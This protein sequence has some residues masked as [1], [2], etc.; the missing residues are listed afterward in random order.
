MLAVLQVI[1]Q[2]LVVGLLCVLLRR[3]ALKPEQQEGLVDV[4]RWAWFILI[5]QPATG[6]RARFFSIRSPEEEVHP[7]D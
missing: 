2:F 7:E 3:F 4:W 5:L 6:G 1:G